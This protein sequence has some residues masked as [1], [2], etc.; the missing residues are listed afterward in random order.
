MPEEKKTGVYQSNEEAIADYLT[1]SSRSGRM[2]G[3]LLATGVTDTIDA[4]M[5][6]EHERHDGEP[7]E[8]FDDILFAISTLWASGEAGIITGPIDPK[9]PLKLML[10]QSDAF[11]T[12][13]A[14]MVEQQI[15][16]AADLLRAHVEMAYRDKVGT[17][18]PSVPFVV[19][20]AAGARDED[21]LD[22]LVRALRAR[23]PEG[24]TAGA[25]AALR[26]GHG[27]AGHVFTTWLI[28]E[29]RRGT[30]QRQAVEAMAL[31]FVASLQSAIETKSMPVEWQGDTM[32]IHA[33]AELAIQEIQDTMEKSRGKRS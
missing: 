26:L 33:A 14:S 2:F 16:R 11:R 6:A 3:R 4:W 5:K 12:S 31:W 17:D 18:Q 27:I 21:T 1:S 7:G 32:D 19:P 13:L 28:D 25:E 20:V 22:P 15:A 30:T 23:N 9:M 24:T 29:A 10:F 8:W